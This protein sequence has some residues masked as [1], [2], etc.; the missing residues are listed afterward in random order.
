MAAADNDAVLPGTKWM[1]VDHAIMSNMAL[2]MLLR[3]LG[4]ETTVHGFRSSFRDWCADSAQPREL[5]E[6]ALA[7]K[8]AGVEGRYLRSDMIERRA[9]LM[10]AWGDYVAPAGDDDKVVRISREVAQGGVRRFGETP[11]HVS[12]RRVTAGS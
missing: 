6:A 10:A 7:H 1:D 5:A 11:Q 9:V 2:L 3:Q 8:V 12:P 4:V